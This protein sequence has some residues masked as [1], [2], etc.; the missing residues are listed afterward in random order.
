MKDST[1]EYVILGILSGKPRTGYEIQKLVKTRMG[2]FWDI[3]YSQIYPSLRM[4]EKEGF[5]TKRLETNDREQNRKVYSITNEGI[6]KLQGWLKEAAK[7]ETF[8][9]EVLLKIA[10]GD[11]ASDDEI[12]KHIKE[13]KARTITQLENI[14][15]VEKE[16]KTHLNESERAFFSLLTLSLGKNLH[17]SAIEWADCAIKLIEEHKLKDGKKP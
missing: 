3:G 1:N 4:L 7:P 11:Q 14:V 17:R 16:M 12:I 13:L 10:F 9:F 5:I 15:A 2:S 6:L 8:K